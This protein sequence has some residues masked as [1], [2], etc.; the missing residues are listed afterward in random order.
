MDRMIVGA[1]TAAL[2][3]GLMV[4]GGVT[5]GLQPTKSPAACVDMANHSADVLRTTGKLM[6]AVR[7]HAA[8]TAWDRRA[9]LAGDIER[10]TSVLDQA[11]PEYEADHAACL[12]A[13]R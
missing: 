9:V 1:A 13:A 7:A 11:A 5:Y 2:C 6:T 4:G 3:V 10:L 12:E 8:E